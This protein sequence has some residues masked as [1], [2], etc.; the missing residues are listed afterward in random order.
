MA[1]PFLS[2]N[3]L[4]ALG[5]EALVETKR[6]GRPVRRV[7]LGDLGSIQSF[8]NPD[9]LRRA[10]GV[11]LTL[12][13]RTGIPVVIFETTHTAAPGR[14]KTLTNMTQVSEAPG[15]PGLADVNIELDDQHAVVTDV[16]GGHR[17]RQR[18]DAL[19]S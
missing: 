2:G 19:A 6:A 11:L 4:L 1:N 15:I 8:W 13:R 3:R 10:V 16:R 14:P 5:I 9:G 7:L 18:L 17:H 12:L